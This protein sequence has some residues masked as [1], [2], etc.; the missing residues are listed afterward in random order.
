MCLSE[1]ERAEQNWCDVAIPLVS[2]FYQY[3]TDTSDGVSFG[4]GR[5]RA[6]ETAGFALSTLHNAPHDA[7]QSEL[8][9]NKLSLFMSVCPHILNR[10]L[11]Q[12][13]HDSDRTCSLRFVNRG[14]PRSEQPSHIQD[15]R[16]ATRRSTT[17]IVRVGQTSGFVWRDW[18][19]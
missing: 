11:L 3:A 18:I 15:G 7:Q 9:C 1:C 14:R 6:R 2:V 17:S 16:K 13:T 10:T 19:R 8:E 5:E 4:R 12:P